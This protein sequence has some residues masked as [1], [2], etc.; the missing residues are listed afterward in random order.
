R[1]VTLVCGLYVFDA[2]LFTA[3][4]F[5][6]M[7]R[8]SLL[9]VE[10]LPS[11]PVLALHVSYAL[12]ACPRDM[13]DIHEEIVVGAFEHVPVIGQPAFK[14]YHWIVVHAYVLLGKVEQGLLLLGGYGEP[15]AYVRYV[16]AH[17]TACVGC[18]IRQHLYP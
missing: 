12:R 7:F 4:R 1:E 14:A 18:V 13:Y 11:V 10:Y 17:L 9:C 8:D 2:S 15:R 3:I 5:V 16:H 6:L